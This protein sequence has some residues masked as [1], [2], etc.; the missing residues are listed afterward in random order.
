MG[1]TRTT[2]DRNL[3]LYWKTGKRSLKKSCS[4]GTG[5]ICPG[6]EQGLGIDSWAFRAVDK[7]GV[8]NLLNM[9]TSS[10]SG[11]QSP[12]QCQDWGGGSGAET[13]SVL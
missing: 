6:V 2:Q 4:D 11:P 5:D 7:V 3:T 1:L 13:E 9:Q 12:Q 10:D 8:L